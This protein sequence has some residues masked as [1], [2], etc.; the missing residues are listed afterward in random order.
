MCQE[1]RAPGA[2]CRLEL[3]Y[4]SHS[5]CRVHTSV[6]RTPWSCPGRRQ[7]ARRAASLAP[8]PLSGLGRYCRRRV[9][10]LQHLKMSTNQINFSTNAYKPWMRFV[11][12]GLIS[13]ALAGP[14]WQHCTRMVEQVV[15]STTGFSV[16][17][18]WLSRAAETDVNAER[19]LACK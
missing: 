3:H 6:F 14:N 12:L 10:S 1:R 8:R 15:D 19:Q 9:C 5:I 4:S 17:L 7:A 18:S 13:M 11:L 16:I 2:S